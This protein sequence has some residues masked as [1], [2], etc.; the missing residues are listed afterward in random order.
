MRLAAS[1]QQAVAEAV[2]LAEAVETAG[3]KQSQ[4]KR[5]RSRRLAASGTV[6]GE[7]AGSKRSQ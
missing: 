1:R 4:E 6:A 2:R 3:S 5:R 7:A